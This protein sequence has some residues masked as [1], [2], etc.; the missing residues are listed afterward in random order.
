MQPLAGIT[1][2][3]LE[4]AIAA[5]FCTRQLAE[6]GARVIKVE[7]PGSGDFARGYDSRVKGLASHFVWT[8]RAKES[9]SLDLKHAAAPAILER[10]LE[11]ADVLVQNLAPG[12]AAR[13]GLS[14]EALAERH[15]KLIVCD[16]SGYG[17]DLE[18]PGPYRDQKAYDLLIQ[19]ESGFLSI[20]GTPDEPAKA[21]CSIADI[22]AAMYAYSGILAALI[23][24]GRTGRGRR[25]DISMLESMVEWMG[26]PLYYAFDGAPPPPRTGASHATIYPYGPFPAGDGGI[27]MLGLQNEREWQVFCERVLERPELVAD[28]RFASNAARTAARDALRAIIVE[29]FRPMS[30][31][32]VTARLDTAQ[33]AN[34]RVNTMSEVWAHPQLR[35]RNRWTTVETPSGPVPALVP[36][37]AHDASEVR[38]DPVPALGAHTDALLAELG[39]DGAAIARLYA[40]GAV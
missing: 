12:A 22:A 28:P 5:P 10:L 14:Y 13:I 40:A 9:L 25:I 2:V 26:Y 30:A 37:G 4:H 21:G 38:M 7:R 19:S 8:N 15:P 34:A 1:V 32:Q 36:P 29:T 24:R 18:R 33:I 27:V 31:E 23:E 3:T 17:D 35:A 16:I 6:L 20:T 11:R 39:Y